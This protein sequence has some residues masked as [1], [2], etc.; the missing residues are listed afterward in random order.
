MKGGIWGF[1]LG[2]PDRFKIESALSFIKFYSNFRFTR[3]F[4]LSERSS[5]IW[6]ASVLFI[7]KCPTQAHLSLNALYLGNEL[8]RKI[9]LLLYQ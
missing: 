6:E 7:K 5:C 2:S 3:F 9:N 4:G 8:H 1:R